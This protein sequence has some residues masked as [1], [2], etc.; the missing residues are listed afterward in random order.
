MALIFVVLLIAQIQLF[1]AARPQVEGR[2]L[3]YKTFVDYVED[4]RVRTACLLDQ[5]A[6]VVG[7]Y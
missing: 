1:A 4:G 6:Y 5:D 2:Q 7:R 3:T